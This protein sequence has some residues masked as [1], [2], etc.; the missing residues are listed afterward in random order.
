MKKYTWLFIAIWSFPGALFGLGTVTPQ[1]SSQCYIMYDAG[2]SG[3]RLYIYENNGKH[4]FEHQGPKVSA[5]ADPIREIRG[6]SNQDIDGVTSEVVSA[7]EVIRQNGPTGK[8]GKPEWQAFDWMARCHIVSAKVFATAG[9][10]IAEQENRSSSVAL[11][12]TLKQK[13]VKKLG[14][15]VAV[16]TH[17]LSGYEEG[18]YAW[19]T[20]REKEKHNNFGIVEMGGVSSQITFPCPKCNAMDDSVKKIMVDGRPI[21]ILSY[22]FLGLGQDEAPK[23]LGMPNSCEYG[24][25]RV[26]ADWEERHCADRI[27]IKNVQGIRDPYNYAGNKRGTHF[28]V[29]TR[30]ANI[31][32]WFLTGAFNSSE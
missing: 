30:K 9:M 16:V 1:A 12:K 18:L 2:S 14:F 7:L 28:H 27:L 8:S 10:R 5:L 17:T 19:L 32:K 4:W 13:L 26:R 22:S 20:V 15:S 21:Q 29:P 3:T 31:V 6:K 24:I 23:S 25:G 11:W